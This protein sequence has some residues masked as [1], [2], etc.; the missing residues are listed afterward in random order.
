MNEYIISLGEE[1]QDTDGTAYYK[2]EGIPWWSISENIVKRLKPA[3]QRIEEA[4]KRGCEDAWSLSR[5]MEGMSTWE[6][7]ATFGVDED[8]AAFVHSLMS[9]EDAVQ[10]YHKH[11]EISEWMDMPADD[12]TLEQARQAVKELRARSGMRMIGRDHGARAG[13]D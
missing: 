7:R 3:E 1:Q 2:V 6:T 8:N 11:W 4:Y 13:A 9:Y 5:I 12:M 10:K